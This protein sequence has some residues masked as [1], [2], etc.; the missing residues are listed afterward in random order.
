MNLDR[1]NEF[2]SRG[3]SPAEKPCRLVERHG[4]GSESVALQ[5][6]SNSRSQVAGQGFLP[7][8]AERACGPRSF[9]EIWI[10]VY[11]H[12]DDSRGRGEPLQTPRSFYPVH[13][14]AWRCPVS[15]TSGN[16]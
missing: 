6:R 12:K 3:F 9:N 11:R 15:R 2:R 14:A 8:V 16:N 7:H 10:R 13:Y 5:D 1:L 4:R